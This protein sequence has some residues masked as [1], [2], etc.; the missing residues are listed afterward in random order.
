MHDSKEAEHSAGAVAAFHAAMAKPE[1]GR[2]EYV[3]NF[4]NAAMYRSLADAQ[5]NLAAYPEAEKSIRKALAY[6]GQ[7]EFWKKY[8]QEEAARQ[9]QAGIEVISF[10]AATGKAF[11][12]KSKGATSVTR[13]RTLYPDC[14]SASANEALL[15]LA[16]LVI[17]VVS[18][19]STPRCGSELRARDRL[20]RGMS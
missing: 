14:R 9:K 11:V 3:W 12:E 13:L 19:G 10:D 7:N 20:I 2:E 15:P 8:N 5:Y 6:E 18:T 16:G 17:W 1:G 4:N